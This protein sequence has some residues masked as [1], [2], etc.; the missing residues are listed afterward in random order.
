M[1]SGK[2]G[3]VLPNGDPNPITAMSI[4]NAAEKLSP[5]ETERRLRISYEKFTPES[6]DSGGP[7]EKGWEDERGLSME[8]DRIDKEEGL[9]A[10]DLA[11]RYLHE[12]LV[13]PSS[14]SGW[15]PGLWYTQYKAE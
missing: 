13:E 1:R 3:R 2:G 14:S 6:L 10:V 7:A 4:R 5:D 12:R 15:N 8:P 11:A 9:T